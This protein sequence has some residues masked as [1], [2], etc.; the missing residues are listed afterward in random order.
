[1]AEPTLKDVLNAIAGFR[2]DSERRLAALEKGQGEIRREMATKKDVAALDA[3]VEAVRDEV[4][5]ARA[6][7]EAGFAET[8]ERFDALDKRLDVV[9]GVVASTRED[10]RDLRADVTTIHKGLV[11]AKVPGVPKDLPSQVRAKGERPSKPAKKRK[12]R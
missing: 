11:R 1:M 7:V 8:R 6:D 4:D 5:A 9:G 3:K 12:A 2:A 10:T